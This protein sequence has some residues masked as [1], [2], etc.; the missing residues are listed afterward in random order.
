MPSIFTLLSSDGEYIMAAKDVITRSVMIRYMLEDVGERDEP[1]PLPNVSGAVLRKV[2]EYC[3]H[4][5]GEA[6]GDIEDDDTRRKEIEMNEWDE[7]FISVNKET[8]FK[9][10][11]AANYLDIKPL[12]EL[13]CKAIA[14]TIKGMSTKEMR[15]FFG[16]VN[17]FTPEEEVSIRELHLPCL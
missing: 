4:Y 7:K 2:L 1:I 11:S 12:L 6:L 13:G 16:V 14:L 15:Q 10:I 17:D 8:L 3:E 5:R 9:I